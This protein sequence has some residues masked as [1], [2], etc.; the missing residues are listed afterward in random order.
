MGVVGGGARP[1][2]VVVERQTSFAVDALRVMTTVADEGP[3]SGDQCRRVAATPGGVRVDLVGGASVA[4]RAARVRS[5]HT[6]R[7]VSVALA[8]TTHGEVGQSVELRLSTA[9]ANTSSV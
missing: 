4:H 8:A 7:R 5:R 3:R 1:R 9:S 6:A 2:T